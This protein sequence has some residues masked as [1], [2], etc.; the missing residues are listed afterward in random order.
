VKF[1]VFL[2]IFG[3]LAHPAVLAGLAADAEDAGWDGVFVWD[4]MLYR[5]PVTDVTDPWIALTAIALRTSSVAIGPMVT[6]LARRR[7]HV[8]ARQVA[9][10]EQLAPGRFILGVGL[11]GDPGGELS[12]LGEETDDRTRAAM[13][14]EALDLVRALLSGETL[15]HAGAYYTAR[16][17]RFSPAPRDAVPVWTAARWPNAAPIRR[18]ARTDGLFVID[19]PEP[20]M[21]AA[22]QQRIAEARG[23]LDDF[24][25]VVREAD[26]ATADGW[27]AVGAT[28]WLQDF[29]PFGV[30]QASARARIQAGPPR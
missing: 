4:H 10:I 14:D 22:A 7:P 19:M 8:V 6:P 12:R 27:A 24:D 9:A 28:W 1:G 3:E 29:D 21:L 25:F 15:D 16:D 11:G 17:V 20:S 26:P 13:L 5:E 30:T 2:P 23:S 18:A